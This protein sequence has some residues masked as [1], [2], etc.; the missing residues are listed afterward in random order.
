MAIRQV[1]VDGP[2]VRL[3]A[4]MITESAPCPSCHTQSTKIHDRYVRRPADLPWRGHPVRLV[5]TVRR[6][7]CV[8]SA[9]DRA[10]FAENCGP[11]LP[12]YARRT[13]DAQVY[14]FQLACTSG[15]EVGARLAAGAGLPVSPDTLL[16]LL[17]EAAL[18]TNPTPH[19]LG[20][21][22]LA[23]RRRQV[24]ATIFVDLETGRVVD[25]VEGRE[26]EMLAK[27]LTAHPGVEIMTRDRAEAYAEGARTGAPQA[28]QVADRFHLLQNASAA[29]DG[30]LRGRR[31]SIEEQERSEP[32][33]EVL[34]PL[35]TS[36]RGAPPTSTRPPSPTKR[37]QIERRAARVARWEHVKELA[38]AGAGF[39]QI[40]R[41][42]GISR[43][44]VHRLLA[45]PEPPRNRVVNR[46]PG[47]LKSPTLQPYV[48]YLQDRWQAGC[49]NVS[50]LY[51]EI[52]GQ[53]YPGSRSLLAQA[54]QTWRGPPLPR[55]ERRKVRRMTRRS[56]MRWLC[57][58]PPEQ[59]ES[60]EQALLKQL[61]SQ[62]GELA[63]GYELLQGFRRVIAKRDTAA[64]EEWMI[65]ARAS[66]L[67][68]FVSLANGI[69]ADRMAVNAA[70]TLPWSNGPVEGQITRVKLIKRQGYGRAKVDLLRARVL[71]S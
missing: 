66:D 63:M 10:T 23:L 15:G 18:P 19:V 70:L 71:A 55:A 32:V 45:A 21:D 50:Q 28:V 41:E 14:L 12:R 16:R 67:P 7:R 56:S 4:E 35:G 39:R 51:R 31:L 25:L 69:E 33:A 26:A 44:T 6:F 20:V 68:T 54:V 37:Y 38:A 58:R 30:M 60:D 57:L 13:A 59:L 46:R 36:D 53:G 52:A 65:T 34:D 5:V 3:Q 27:W 2:I 29:L 61:L 11:D 48:S 43:K 62:D 22:D 1:A 40:A 47:G 49:T 42:V 64:L 24:Y 9:C 17:R 8:N